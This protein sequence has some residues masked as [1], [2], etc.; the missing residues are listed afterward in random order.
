MFSR[1]GNLKKVGFLK[2]QFPVQFVGG[3]EELPLC[4]LV[5]LKHL[6]LS[7]SKVN[8]RFQPATAALMS[9]FFFFLQQYPEDKC[10]P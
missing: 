6:T 8:N 9:D 3:E 2:N 1:R 10:Y 5:L 7:G 4:L